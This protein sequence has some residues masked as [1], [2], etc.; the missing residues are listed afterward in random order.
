MTST[1]LK[2]GKKSHKKMTTHQ[3]FKLLMSAVFCFNI[4]YRFV[5]IIM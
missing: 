1:L 5:L 3:F 2:G 4:L